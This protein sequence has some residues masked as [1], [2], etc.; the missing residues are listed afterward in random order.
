MAKRLKSE[1]PDAYL[2]RNGLEGVDGAL[3]EADEKPQVDLKNI[4]NINQP[5]ES[6]DPDSCKTC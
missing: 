5:K 4:P 1:S 2:K 3:V 6:S